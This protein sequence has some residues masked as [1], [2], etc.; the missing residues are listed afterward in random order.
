MYIE[1]A[2]TVKTRDGPTADGVCVFFASFQV[3]VLPST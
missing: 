2:G 3:L 1:F